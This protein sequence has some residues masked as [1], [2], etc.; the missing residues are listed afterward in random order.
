[1]ADRRNKGVGRGNG[2]GSRETQFQKGM[3]SA[4]PWGRPVKVKDEPTGSLRIALERALARR[5]MIFDNGKRRR[6]TQAEAMAET[7]VARFPKASMSEMLQAIRYIMQVVPSPEP[8]TRG[9]D[10]EGVQKFVERL[11][12]EARKAEEIERQFRSGDVIDHGRSL[13]R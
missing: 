7:Y 12:E 11:A 13:A 8:E 3:P 5:I 9:L 1:M 2:P 10:P 4:N 6:M